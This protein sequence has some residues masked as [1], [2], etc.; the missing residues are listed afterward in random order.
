[1]LTWVNIAREARNSPDIIMQRKHGMTR[2]AQTGRD[3][4]ATAHCQ[5]IALII[6]ST[7]EEYSY[8]SVL[9]N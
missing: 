3:A 8:D 9:S 2:D 5:T 4:D 6:E 7:T 1:M